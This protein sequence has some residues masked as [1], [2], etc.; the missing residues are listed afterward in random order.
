MRFRGMVQDTPASPEMYL[1]HTG[2]R[3]GGW[4]LLFD[5]HLADDVDYSNLAECN[6]FWIV[7][8]PGETDWFVSKSEGDTWRASPYSL[9]NMLLCGR[10]LIA[11]ISSIEQR[12]AFSQNS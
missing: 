9:H 8:V 3:C 6:A 5:Q 7:S 11:D 12:S 10:G 1:S 4:G 2:A